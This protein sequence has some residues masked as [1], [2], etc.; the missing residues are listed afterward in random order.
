MG[1]SDLLGQLRE[2]AAELPA[3]GP[4]EV[5]QAQQRALQ[6]LAT[7]EAALR[8]DPTLA[9]EDRC[10]D[11]D[12]LS[13]V[14]RQLRPLARQVQVEMER[15]RLASQPGTERQIARLGR[16]G[17]LALDELDELSQHAI[18]V[19]DRIAN[20][21]QP[22]WN[23]PER[24][25]ERSAR[26]LPSP[27]MLEDIAAQ[28]RY[29][30]RASL[31]LPYPDPEAVRLAALADQITL[32]T[33]RRRA[34]CGGPGCDRDLD[35]APTGRPR[36]YCGAACRQRARRAARTATQ[37]PADDRAE[38]AL[39]ARLAT[40]PPDTRPLPSVAAYDDL[41]QRRPRAR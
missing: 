3:A 18:T 13:E 1:E 27:A 5:L 24:F 35:H 6:A 22:D 29:A 8:V 41:L 9:A 30:V 33:Q 15:R 10:G 21:A 31:E 37:A 39:Q 32:T 16:T 28:L 7:V 17:P 40:L 4:P 12:V 11:L 14:L 34:R 19:A 26:L 20:A 36:R 38:D 23:T 25:R 2:K